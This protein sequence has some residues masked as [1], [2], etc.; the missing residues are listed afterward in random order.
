LGNRF[1]VLMR[2]KIGGAILVLD[3]EGAR[4]PRQCR[5]AANKATGHCDVPDSLIAGIALVNG[6]SVATHNVDDFKHF[7]VTLV[8]PWMAGA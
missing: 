5:A 2:S 7:G 1:D 6:A 3:P 4:R 8:D